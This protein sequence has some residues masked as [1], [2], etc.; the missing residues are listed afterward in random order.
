M[1]PA[2]ARHLAELHAAPEV[3]VEVFHALRVAEEWLELGPGERRRYSLA[4]TGELDEFGKER[5]LGRVFRAPEGTWRIPERP[6]VPYASDRAAMAAVDADLQRDGW[7]L[8]GGAAT[9]EVS[10]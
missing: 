3:A 6:G 1:S 2:A 9:A 8:V 10:W 4:H 5:P 7:V